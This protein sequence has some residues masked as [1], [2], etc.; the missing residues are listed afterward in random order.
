MNLLNGIYG[1]VLAFIGN[2]FNGEVD[3]KGFIHFLIQ[4]LTLFSLFLLAFNRFFHLY[5]K[6]YYEKFFSK[7]LIFVY[8]F[9][10]DSLIIAYDILTFEDPFINSFL[11]IVIFFLTITLSSLLIIKIYLSA[12]LLKEHSG[13]LSTLRDIKTAALGCFLRL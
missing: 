2:E 3:T 1:E 12:K 5:L 4:D 13:Q 8:I 6:H 11:Q 7:I 9:I 10:Y